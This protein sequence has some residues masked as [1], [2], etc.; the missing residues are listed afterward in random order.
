M[1][2]EYLFNCGL[3]IHSYAPNNQESQA[4]INM[5]N[6][7]AHCGNAQGRYIVHPS[8]QR[9][10]FVTCS[11][12]TALAVKQHDPQVNLTRFHAM[13]TWRIK[14][15]ADPLNEPPTVDTFGE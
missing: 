13:I 3:I 6:A 12:I 4:E 5:M 8:L 1:L 7:L 2:D 11:R 9:P 15:S 14:G 10:W